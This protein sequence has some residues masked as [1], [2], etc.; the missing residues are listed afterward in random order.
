MLQLIET[1]ASPPEYYVWQRWGRVGATGQST[2]KGPSSLAVAMIQ[3]LA[4]FEDKTKNEF[5]KRPFTPHPDKYTVV[6]TA[7]A[8]AATA[9]YSPGL[10]AIDFEAGVVHLATWSSQRFVKALDELCGDGEMRIGN[11]KA[12]DEIDVEFMSATELADDAFWD[13]TATVLEVF[14]AGLTTNRDGMICGTPGGFS[15]QNTATGEVKR[16]TTLDLKDTRID[17]IESPRFKNLWETHQ[18]QLVPVPDGIAYAD[19]VVPPALDAALNA[20][21]D[22]LIALEPEDYHPGSGM[23]VRDLVHPSL[24]PYVAGRSIRQSAAV[25]ATTPEFDRF[26]RKY[27]ASRYQWLPTPFQIDEHGD[28]TIP[29]YINNLSRER[30]QDAYTNLALLFSL[31]LPLIESVVGYVDRAEFYDDDAK[32]APDEDAP[33]R[34]DPDATVPPTSLRS[35]DLLVI[36]KIVEYQLRPGETHEGVWHVEGMSHEHIVATCVYVLSRDTALEGGDL[37]FKRAYT[38]AEASLLYWNVPQDRPTAFNTIVDEG[39]VPI[40]RVPLPAGRLLVFPNSHIHK[41]TKLWN[42]Q[43]EGKAGETIGAGKAGEAGEGVLPGEAGDASDAR[44]AAAGPARRRVI[45]FWVVDPAVTDMP[46]TFD[47]APQQDGVLTREEA[48]AMRLELMEERKRHKQ[49]LNVR[50]VSLCEH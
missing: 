33:A 2:L 41:L 18:Q 22:R 1:G 32:E 28:V 11:V 12:G 16:L 15:I 9:Q 17:I 4:K 25:P 37:L 30:H 43:E 20:D 46:S 42:T 13:H 27:E 40:G 14:Q 10:G 21:V 19:G 45:V 38:L 35:R 47:V 39:T 34:E 24:Y 23:R 44:D 6:V 3:F 31:A 26:G 50:A 7:R 36:P 49:N 29:T 5:W 8:V 48:L